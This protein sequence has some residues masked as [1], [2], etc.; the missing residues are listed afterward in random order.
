MN[1]DYVR[2]TSFGGKL[3]YDSN[4]NLIGTLLRL[5]ISHR[6]KQHGRFMRFSVSDKLWKTKENQ[7]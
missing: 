1:I 6:K 7:F 2:P 4:M 3:A 5:H